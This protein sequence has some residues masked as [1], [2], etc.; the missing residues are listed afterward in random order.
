MRGNGCCDPAFHESLKKDLATFRQN[1]T[2][3]GYLADDE[4]RLELRNCRVPSCMS[5]LAM[6]VEDR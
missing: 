2:H 4:E 5:T 1:T 6:V 3:V